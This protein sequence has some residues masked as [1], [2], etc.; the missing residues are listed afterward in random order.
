MPS[1]NNKTIL[2]AHMIR[3]ALLNKL[4]LGNWGCPEM[5]LQKRVEEVTKVAAVLLHH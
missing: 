5:S 1:V 3:D 4:G 2:R